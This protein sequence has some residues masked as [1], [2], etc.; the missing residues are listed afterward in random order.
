MSRKTRMKLG[1]E[2]YEKLESIFEYDDRERVL[3]TDEY[4]WCLI[5]CLDIKFPNGEVG[6]G[7]GWLIGKNKILTAGHC[8]YDTGKGGW[9][10]SITVIPGNDVENPYPGNKSDDAP[11]GKYEAVAMQTTNEWFERRSMT[12]DVAVIHIDYPIADD[13]GNFGISIYDEDD[14]L[15]GQHIRVAGYPMT[16][17]PKDEETQGYYKKRVAGQMWTH[18]DK[19]INVQDGQVFY[20]LDTSGGQSG[21]PVMLLGADALGLVAMGIHNYGFNQT[22]RYHE[23]KASLITLEVWKYI[24]GWLAEQYQINW[25]D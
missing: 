13:L 7:T 22:D 19:I 24:E 6:I 2:K 21:A 10:A 15:I 12:Y 5:A 17:F 20:N 14:D 9:A 8:V 3:A 16:H 11:Y 23:N 4:P 1:W 18:S 25:V